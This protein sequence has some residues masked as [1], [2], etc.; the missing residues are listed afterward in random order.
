[1]SKLGILEPPFVRWFWTV[2]VSLFALLDRPDKSERKSVYGHL[3]FCPHLSRTPV[4]PVVEDKGLDNK[5][6]GVLSF[7]LSPDGLSLVTGTELKGDEAHLRFWYENDWPITL[8]NHSKLN[9]VYLPGMYGT[10]LNQ[11][12]RIPLPIQ[13]I[14]PPS[15]F[16]PSV[17]PLMLS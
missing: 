6:R 16:P 14:S 3:N 2:S 7:D 10:P 1:M 17:D 4:I 13:T 9:H 11:R 5:S 15:R 8:H 12:I